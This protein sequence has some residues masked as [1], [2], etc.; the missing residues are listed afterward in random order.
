[1]RALGIQ[2]QVTQ[3]LSETNEVGGYTMS[4]VCTV[5]GLVVASA[6][7]SMQ[8]DDTAAFTS[9]FQ[10]ILVRAQRDLGFRV[11]DEVTLLDPGRGRFVIRPLPVDGENSLFLVVR[12]PPGGTWRRNTTKLAAQLT[13]VLRPLVSTG[14]AA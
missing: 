7:E 2:D 3:L 6:G 1:M 4:L 10:D 11:V 8:E 14:D 12:V 9:L 13:E 5:T